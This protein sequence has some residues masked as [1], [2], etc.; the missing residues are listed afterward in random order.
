MNLDIYENKMTL[1][2]SKRTGE[3]QTF[4]TGVQDMNFFGENKLDYEL[5]WDFLVLDYDQR[6]LS[7]FNMF[8]VD[9]DT[10]KLKIVDLYFK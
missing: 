2:Y 6:V 5:I 3:I 8:V 10:K 4:C 1:F 7:N 9:I